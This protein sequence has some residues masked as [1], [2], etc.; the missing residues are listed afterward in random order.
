MADDV[1]AALGS[2]AKARGY[3]R[4]CRRLSEEL[5]ALDRQREA[6]RDSRKRIAEMME[7]LK[8][9]GESVEFVTRSQIPQPYSRTNPHP[10]RV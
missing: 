2:N 9:G 8:Q 1:A 6:A 4:A 7:L 5:Y 10:P 3:S